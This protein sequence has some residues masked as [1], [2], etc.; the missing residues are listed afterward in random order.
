MADSLNKI[1]LLVQAAVNECT[2]KENLEEAANAVIER[3]KTR[4]RLGK[5]VNKPEG[6]AVPLKKL[7]PKTVEVRKALQKAGKLSGTGAK[8]SKSGINR[9]G[10]TLDS[11]HAVAKNKEVTIQLDNDGEKVATE[12]AAIDPSRFTFMNLSKAEVKAMTDILE[13]KVQKLDQK[14]K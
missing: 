6:N 3:V 9:T 13:E 1:N 4:T 12:L 7:E 2:R 8:P 11:M 14:T 5:G 10:K